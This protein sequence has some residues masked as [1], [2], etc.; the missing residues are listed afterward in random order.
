MPRLLNHLAALVCLVSASPALACQVYRHETGLQH[1]DL[2]FVGDLQSVSALP[3]T[4]DLKP[5]DAVFRITQLV[6]GAAPQIVTIRDRGNN[7]Y[8][9]AQFG[10]NR[11][12]KNASSSYLV[13]AVKKEGGYETFHPLPNGQSNEPDA[14]RFLQ[15]L[16]R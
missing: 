4:K 10:P 12:Q 16:P 13:F 15:N 2:V 5:A 14:Q 3:Q 11:G 6:K 7:C 9:L 1:A 8:G